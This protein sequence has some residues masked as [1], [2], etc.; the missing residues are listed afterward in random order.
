MFSRISLW[1][2]GWRDRGSEY[3]IGIKVIVA[4]VS[5]SL[6]EMGGLICQALAAHDYLGKSSHLIGCDS[7]SMDVYTVNT[8][9]ISCHMIGTNKM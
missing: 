9:H 1:R 3:A 4:D 6:T 2:T 8:S 7:Y 5:E